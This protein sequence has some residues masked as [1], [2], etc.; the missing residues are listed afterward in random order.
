[1]IKTIPRIFL[2]CLQNCIQNTGRL[3]Y[4]PTFCLQHSHHIKFR[5]DDDTKVKH[6]QQEKYN[7]K[8]FYSR[9]FKAILEYS[10]KQPKQIPENYKQFQKENFHW[11]FLWFTVQ[12]LQHLKRIQIQTT[13]NFGKCSNY[14]LTN[15]AYYLYLVLQ[16]Y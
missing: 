7:T 1:M 14:T 3:T 9:I 13:R 6:P 2:E 11:W 4:S 8:F 5:N 16:R 10:V 12:T 15:S